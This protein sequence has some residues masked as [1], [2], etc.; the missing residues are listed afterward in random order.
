MLEEEKTKRE[1]EEH[2]KQ[3]EEEER[4]KVGTQIRFEMFMKSFCLVIRQIIPFIAFRG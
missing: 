1:V 3:L 4:N 2:Q